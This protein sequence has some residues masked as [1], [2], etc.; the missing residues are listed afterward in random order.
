MKNLDELIVELRQVYD[1]LNELKESNKEK[2]IDDIDFNKI[3][4]KAKTIPLKNEILKN[5]SE[6][7]QKSYLNL[8]ASILHFNNLEDI[9]QSQMLYIARIVEGINNKNITLENVYSSSMDMSIVEMNEAITQISK[10]MDDL[11]VVD[12]MICANINGRAKDEILEYISNI[13]SLMDVKLDVMKELIYLANSILLLD[14]DRILDTKSVVDLNRFNYAISSII[15]EKIFYNLEDIK[16]NEIGDLILLKSEI[17]HIEEAINFDRYKFNSI[18]FI[19]CKF[20]DIH[21]I[22]CLNKKFKFINCVFENIKESYEKEN[23]SIWGRKYPVDF[24]ELSNVDMNGCKFTNCNTSGSL[25]K[26]SNCKLENCE[27]LN[28]ASN[29]KRESER[30][31]KERSLF[32]INQG[33]INNIKISSCYI[34]RRVGNRGYLTLMNILNSKVDNIQMYECEVYTDTDYGS[35]AYLYSYIINGNNINLKNSYFKECKA[36]TVDVNHGH[37]YEYTLNLIDSIENNNKFINCSC[38][39]NIGQ[40]SNGY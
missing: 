29:K 36:S 12:M 35:Y 11:F 25:I 7:I 4:N 16:E 24:I 37:Y 38:H 18:K 14:R 20:N 15:N 30:L 1:D 26:L 3:K 23:D 5:S 33:K 39:N 13:F 22:Y 34:Y 21:S 28:C 8:L 19:N 31:Y 27:F 17:N 40:I 6:Y 32:I 2:K 9:R 10:Y